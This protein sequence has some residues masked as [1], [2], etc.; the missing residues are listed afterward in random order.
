M[1]RHGSAR[2]VIEA[3]HRQDAIV[4]V[5]P[6]PRQDDADPWWRH[7]AT[8]RPNAPRIIARLPFAGS[9]WRPC[10]TPEALAICPISVEPTGR[11]RSFIVAESESR[12]DL[13]QLA[14]ALR[15][16]G[17]RPELRRGLARAGG[18]R[19]WLYLAEVEGCL[20]P[21]DDGCSTCGR[22][23]STPPKRL[24][25]VG[26]YA[27]PLDHGDARPAARRGAGLAV[28]SSGEG[29]ERGHPHDPADPPPGDPRHRPIRRRRVEHPRRQSRH[30]AGIER[31][32]AG[33]EPEGA[34]SVSR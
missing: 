30:Q 10:G 2:A 20:A 25:L 29:R 14:R 5:L 11:D 34:R 24:L 28:G 8:S 1:S 16:A 26:G 32:R 13:D 19:S 23:W 15:Q 22:P 21:D 31:E 17:P 12:L 6:M 9:R 33:A 27:V 7:L 18:A 3:V 4:G